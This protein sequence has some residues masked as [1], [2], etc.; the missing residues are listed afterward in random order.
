MCFLV[1][2]YISSHFWV[3]WHHC[4]Q[5]SVENIMKEKMPKKGGRWW[6]SWR[7]RNSDIK[8]VSPQIDRLFFKKLLVNYV[9]MIGSYNASVYWVSSDLFVLQETTTETGD[10]EDGSPTMTSM[11]GWFY[12]SND[13]YII[14]F[15]L[16][17]FSVPLFNQTQ[18]LEYLSLKDDSSSS[19]EDYTPCNQ[20]PE[21][22]QPEA[23]LNSP[24]VCY[25]KTLRL[26]SDQLVQCL[27]LH[28]ISN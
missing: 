17:S 18:C 13:E 15:S 4:S 20:K 6:F 3:V 5:A 23:V 8:S 14:F 1:L 7:R 10:R 16:S 9:K 28:L 24:G 27:F 21:S 25:K 11:N 26:T 2:S 12:P 19:D 22:L